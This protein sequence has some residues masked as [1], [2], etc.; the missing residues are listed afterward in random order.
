[1][2]RRDLVQALARSMPD[3][4]NVVVYPDHPLLVRGPDV[5]ARDDH[6]LV[7]YFVFATR[8]PRPGSV[9]S[10]TRTLLSRLAL[11]EGTE[12][13]L[14]CESRGLE[15]R[16]VDVELFDAVRYGGPP[17]RYH[18][19]SLEP[20]GFTPGGVVA[21]LRPF[22]MRRFGDAWAMRNEDQQLEL[23]TQDDGSERLS[24]GVP[25][26][27]LGGRWVDQWPRLPNSMDF[28]RGVLYASP[29]SIPS[30][31]TAV[32]RQ[33]GQWISAAVDVDYPSTLDSLS[34][35]VAALHLH[36]AYLPLHRAWTG[37]LFEGKA[38][39]ILKPYRAAAFAG[40][41]TIIGGA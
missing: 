23:L 39:D 24:R 5:L 33:I 29:R 6:G 7:A 2:H 14:V 22:H 10:R 15:L 28:S 21:E 34:V 32:I 36:S 18:R 30:N 16:D 38:T 12:F 9:A 25:I 20:S 8:D 31:R 37:P 41:Q 26:S 4:D 11:P 35:A 17:M 3:Q 27:V 13:V 19:S 40:F 1:M